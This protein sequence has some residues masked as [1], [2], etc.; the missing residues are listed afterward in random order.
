MWVGEGGGEFFLVSFSVL[1][2]SLIFHL[3]HILREVGR[4]VVI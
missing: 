3:K 1:K 4:K 2:I